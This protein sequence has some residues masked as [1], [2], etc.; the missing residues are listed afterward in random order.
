MF[1]SRFNHKTLDQRARQLAPFKFPSFSVKKSNI[2]DVFDIQT[3]N[4]LER[5]STV[6]SRLP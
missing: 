3:G 5:V 4:V 2:L 1:F 6:E